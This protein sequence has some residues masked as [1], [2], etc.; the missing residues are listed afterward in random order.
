MFT[1]LDHPS[2]ALVEV[3]ARSVAQVFEEAASAL[4]EIMTDTAAVKP[5]RDFRVEL[6]SGE[7]TGLLIDWL[8]RLILLH[9]TE[10]VFL[11]EF[12]VEVHHDRT[13]KLN[14][15][16][17]GETIR[18]VHERRS[19]AKSATYGQFEWSES[20]EGHRVRFVIDI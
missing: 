16:V 12:K 2:E 13:W 1:F 6:E 9:E 4:F 14:A 18:E 8:N 17:K 3:Q 19:E 11:S 5:E 7:R 20:D 15:T 10:R